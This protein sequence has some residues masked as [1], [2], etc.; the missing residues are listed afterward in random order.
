MK[1]VTAAELFA[2]FYQEEA[3]R[4]ATLNKAISRDK[5][6]FIGC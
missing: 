6:K 1:S 5:A 2:P 4:N 3:I